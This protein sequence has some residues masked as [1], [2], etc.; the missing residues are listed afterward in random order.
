[1]EK[2]WG[3]TRSKWSRVWGLVVQR[4]FWTGAGGQAGTGVAETVTCCDTDKSPESGREWSRQI[5][6]PL[7]R[8]ASAPSHAYS[9]LSLPHSLALAL[10]SYS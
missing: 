1:M 4:Q 2:H 8:F 10:M 3:A 6:A 9:F 7:P 5:E